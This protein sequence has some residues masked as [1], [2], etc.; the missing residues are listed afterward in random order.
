[1]RFV[2]AEPPGSLLQ[3]SFGLKASAAAAGSNGSLALQLHGALIERRS[4][5]PFELP[6]RLRLVRAAP[7]P[8]AP[9]PP[10]RL[11]SDEGERE[12]GEDSY[13]A[14]SALSPGLNDWAFGPRAG[15][16]GV[17]VDD[18]ARDD[19]D[20]GED[21]DGDDDDD[22][23][24]AGG[25]SADSHCGC[26]EGAAARRGVI[27]CTPLGRCKLPAAGG[28]VGACACR[29]GF[30]GADCGMCARGFV[31]FP[32]KCAPAKACARDCGRG[33]CDLVTGECRYPNPS[34][35]P[36]PI[37]LT[38]TLTLTLTPTPTPTLIVTL[39]LNLTLALALTPSPT[40]TLAR[41][42]PL[43]RAARRPAVR[44]VRGGLRWARMRAHRARHRPGLAAH[45]GRRPADKLGLAAH[46]RGRSARALEL[47]AA[48]GAPLARRNRVRAY[49]ART[50]RAHARARA[51]ADG[52]PAHPRH[53]PV[54]RSQ[55]GR[56]PWWARCCCCPCCC[57]SPS[58][59]G[60]RARPT[61]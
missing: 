52:E 47:G 6:P 35:N 54:A 7:P 20:D 53:L 56:L 31:G 4:G 16:G 17:G 9:P 25:C 13:G 8:P 46:W 27:N 12:Y 3:L 42:V 32:P 19:D 11:V 43:P 44:P 61:T 24:G 28:G 57:S 41:R 55:V 36:N 21:D 23:D 45:Q 51:H 60:G 58:W 22:A 50:A 10:E 34:P 26:E 1:M 18:D 30:A 39:T 37:T 40:P 15:G 48:A 29:R 38:L 33:T 59:P 14:E 49:H 5:R 2:P